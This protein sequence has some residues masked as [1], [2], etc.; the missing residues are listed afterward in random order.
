MF[1]V[2]CGWLKGNI[3]FKIIFKMIENYQGK[4]AIMQSMSSGL[5]GG[6][7]GLPSPIDL[8]VGVV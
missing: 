6:G 4:P 8:R 5:G 1:R 3:S 2:E 7:N